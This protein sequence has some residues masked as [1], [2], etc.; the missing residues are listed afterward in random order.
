MKIITKNSETIK[1]SITVFLVIQGNKNICKVE[2]PPIA[3]K[4]STI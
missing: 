4:N 1:K 2:S 3:N